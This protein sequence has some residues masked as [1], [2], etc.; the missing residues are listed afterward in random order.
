MGKLPSSSSSFD[1]TSGFF[2]LATLWNWLQEN[3]FT[4]NS[5]SWLSE[6]LSPTWQ[7][8][9]WIIFIF[10]LIIGTIAFWKRTFQSIQKII[11][12]INLLLV[13]YKKG[14]DLFQDI[15]SNDGR[16]NS[17][18]TSQDNNNMLVTLSLQEKILKKLQMV[19]GKVKDLE[20]L[21]MTYK[22]GRRNCTGPYCSC[23]DCQ[24]PLPTSG[25]TS[26]SEG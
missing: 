24:S 8:I 15:L 1:Q 12:F 2:S 17:Y 25:F 26:T 6:Y 10:V 7:T 18:P 9:F 16:T 11:L 20:D 22:S 23:S 4:L 21:I 13:L 3:E 14:T 19:E 5:N